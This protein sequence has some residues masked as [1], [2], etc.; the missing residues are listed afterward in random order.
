MSAE[1]ASET[2]V[3]SLPR[4][5]WTTGVAQVNRIRL[6]IGTERLLEMARW[7]AVG[8]LFLVINIPLLYSLHDVLGLPV[9]LATLVG[10]EIG[11]IL[12]FLVNDRWVFGNPRPTWLR[13][14]KYQIAVASSFA[15][16]WAVTNA[17]AQI[18]VHYLVANVGGQMASVGWSM[19]T[20]FGWIWRRVARR[21]SPTT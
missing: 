20:N 9:W 8:L 6:K 7:W 17:L 19:L 4:L 16:W 12:R 14:F 2:S 1:P 10:G 13:L 18:G 11:T 3:V 5:A 21:P 15:I